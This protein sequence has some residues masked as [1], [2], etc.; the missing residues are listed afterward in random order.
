MRKVREPFGEEVVKVDSLFRIFGTNLG[1][2][3]FEPPIFS[4]F[5][6]LIDTG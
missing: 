5:K 4:G 2:M 6:Q 3:C 1:L